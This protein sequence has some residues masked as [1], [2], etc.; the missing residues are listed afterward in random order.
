MNSDPIPLTKKPVSSP[1]GAPALVAADTPKTACMDQRDSP[2]ERC[3]AGARLEG[4][5]KKE[6]GEDGD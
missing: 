4:E 1:A 5:E 6:E 2:R 3:R